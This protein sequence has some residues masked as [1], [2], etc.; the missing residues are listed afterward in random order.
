MGLRC[1]IAAAVSRGCTG[2]IAAH[3]VRCLWGRAGSLRPP[4][5]AG[6]AR[7]SAPAWRA[8]RQHPVHR[9]PRG[10][11]LDDIQSQVTMQD[12]SPTSNLCC[13]DVGPSPETTMAQHQSNTDSCCC[14]DHTHSP[15]ILL[16]PFLCFFQE[17]IFLACMAG[18]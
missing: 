16:V 11:R 12:T 5:C 4:G 6:R 17:E 10:G 1:P 3:P 18:V 13:F 2:S 14:R 8:R 9:C 15:C 7:D